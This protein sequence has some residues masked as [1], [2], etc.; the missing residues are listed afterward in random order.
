ML[1][2]C[3]DPGVLPSVL[4]MPTRESDG[5]AADTTGTAGTTGTG[6]GAGEAEGARHAEAYIRG[7]R[8]S[9]VGTAATAAAAAAALAAAEAE[10]AAAAGTT[11][12]QPELPPECAVETAPPEAGGVVPWIAAESTRGAAAVSPAA[13]PPAAREQMLAAQLATMRATTAH[14]A[15]RRPVHADAVE[16]SPDPEGRGGWLYAGGAQPSTSVRTVRHVKRPTKGMAPTASSGMLPSIGSDSRAAGG[17]PT[18][19]SYA[20]F[21]AAPKRDAGGG[22]G[23]S[24]DGDMERWLAE[25]R[26][27]RAADAPGASS[28]PLRRTAS[29]SRLRPRSAAAT[30]RGGGAHVATT[31]ETPFVTDERLPAFRPDPHTYRMDALAAGAR[32]DEAENSAHRSLRLIRQLRELR[33]RELSDARR[34]GLERAE[35]NMEVRGSSGGGGVPPVQGV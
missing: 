3:M 25:G 28:G 24:G 6:A 14:L 11:P 21:R 2:L 29:S 17:T 31:L 22:G 30:A 12:W 35:R 1:A 32:S 20:S 23:G 9:T 4:R 10:G 16:D 7:F 13:G 18:L 8:M 5:A 15:S 34:A 27:A 33:A 19:P 26:A